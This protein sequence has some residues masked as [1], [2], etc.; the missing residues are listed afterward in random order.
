MSD[1]RKLTG[2]WNANRFMHEYI[3]FAN[4]NG[5]INIKDI[6]LSDD[7]PY[8]IEQHRFVAVL[9]AYGVTAENSIRINDVICTHCSVDNTNE[10]RLFLKQYVNGVYY[11]K[12]ID[13]SNF[14]KSTIEIESIFEALFTYRKG[15]YK[16]ENVWDGII[17]CS[18]LYSLATKA[19]NNLYANHIKVVADAIDKILILLLRDEFKRSFIEEE[20]LPYG[21]PDVSDE[22]LHNMILDNF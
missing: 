7:S 16:L 2:I 22:N 20:L 17:E 3:R 1:R 15:L 14:L 9:K 13:D 5:C 11:N 21:Y 8:S 4:E 18:S 10:I 12:L 6:K 19:T